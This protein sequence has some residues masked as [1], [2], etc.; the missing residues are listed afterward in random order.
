M[1]WLCNH[2]KVL[3]SVPQTEKALGVK[4]FFNDNRLSVECALG[5]LWNLEIYK[6]GSVFRFLK[7]LRAN[8]D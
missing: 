6:L 7:G 4:V 2:K 1:K 3:S 8:S 5:I